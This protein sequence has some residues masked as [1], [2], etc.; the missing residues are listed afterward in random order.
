MWKL[1]Y[2]WSKV[3]EKNSSHAHRAHKLKPKSSH[4]YKYKQNT[5]MEWKWFLWAR[6]LVQ[7]KQITNHKQMLRSRA[8]VQIM[9]EY[10]NNHFHEI[11]DHHANAIQVVIDNSTHNF[12]DSFH[13]KCKRAKQQKCSCALSLYF[14]LF[15]MEMQTPSVPCHASKA[16]LNG[17]IKETQLI[18]I[19]IRLTELYISVKCIQLA[20]HKLLFLKGS[21]LKRTF[22]FRI[23][24]FY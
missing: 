21:R 12:A 7:S 11:D 10:N 6:M 18:Y 16:L 1:C 17:I 9:F 14:Y 8:I 2:K 23:K 15:T 20:T 4:K 3:I 22:M 19:L 13:P 24:I 5:K